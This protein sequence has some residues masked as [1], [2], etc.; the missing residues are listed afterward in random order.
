[1][2]SAE[3]QSPGKGEVPVSVLCIASEAKYNVRIGIG[4]SRRRP[5][6]SD[7]TINCRR[8]MDKRSLASH[9]ERRKR[10]ARRGEVL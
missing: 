9:L 7:A 6:G 2:S 8:D 10:M 1:V 3:N 4:I 5:L